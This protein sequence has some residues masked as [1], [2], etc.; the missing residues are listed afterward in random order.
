MWGPEL[1]HRLHPHEASLPRSFSP[2][3]RCTTKLP[4]LPPKRLLKLSLYSISMPLL[5]FKIAHTLLA[6]PQPP[7]PSHLLSIQQLSFQ[8]TCD[9]AFLCWKP[10]NVF[11][12]PQG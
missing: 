3:I 9:D 8:M 7:V 1:M 12:L 5:H 6:Q 11:I 2:T 10:F 4:A